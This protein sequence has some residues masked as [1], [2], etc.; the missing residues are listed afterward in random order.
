LI[1]T[2]KH[3]MPPLALPKREFMEEGRGAIWE[4]LRL[5]ALNAMSPWHG[6]HARRVER[7]LGE[8]RAGGPRPGDWELNGIETGKKRS[9]RGL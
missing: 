3:P 4:E 8:V 2:L 5:P 1:A 7:Q 9:R 6:L